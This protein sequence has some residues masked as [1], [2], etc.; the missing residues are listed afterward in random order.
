MTRRFILS[1]STTP[2]S[3]FLAHVNPVCFIELDRC[4]GCLCGC[5]FLLNQSRSIAVDARRLEPMRAGVLSMF[6]VSPVSTT[7]GYLPHL[8]ATRCVPANLYLWH[9]AGA[10]GAMAVLSL[11]FLK[12]VV[13]LIYLQF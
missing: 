1:R 10:V 8:K 3:N 2:D 11:P 5:P 6:K 13:T 9:Q 12:Q 4:D 7:D